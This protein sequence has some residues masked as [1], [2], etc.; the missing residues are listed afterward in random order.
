MPNPNWKP[1]L[2]CRLALRSRPSSACPICRRTLQRNRDWP[3]E[4][5]PDNPS[6]PGGAAASFA[7]REEHDAYRCPLDNTNAPG[8]LSRKNKLSTYVENGAI[9]VMAA[10]AGGAS[11]K[12]SDSC[13]DAFMMWELTTGNRLWLPRWAGFPEPAGRGWGRRHGKVG[14]IVLMSSQVLSTITVGIGEP[15]FGPKTG[16]GAPRH[17]TGHGSCGWPD[18]QR[19]D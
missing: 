7:V 10:S 9:A 5:T 8:Y 2:G 15:Q 6:G 19:R 11:F 12:Q 13:R 18:S 14:G 3:N 16:S 4:G 17:K 1:A